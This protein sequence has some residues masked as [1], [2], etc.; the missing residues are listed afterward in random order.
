MWSAA[1]SP[2]MI[3][4]ALRLPLVMRGKIEL[5]ATRK[6]STP[7]TRQSGSMTAS[8]SSRAAEA[9]GA[10]GVVGALGVLADEGVELVVGLHVGAGL[11]LVAGVG[12]EGRLGEDLA[13]QADA[14]AEVDPVLLGRHV[15]EAD[16]RRHGRVGALQ[17]DVPR[18]GERIGPTWA[19]KPWP[20]TAERPS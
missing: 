17:A 18:E 11:D 12:A 6:A 5:S 8:G 14:A 2:T 9:G 1:F 16:R 10:A 4:G 20:L 19:W 13:G 7:I 15:V 3:D